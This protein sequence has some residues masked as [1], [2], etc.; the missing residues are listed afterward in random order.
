MSPN[1]RFAVL[2]LG[3][4]M[5]VAGVWLLALDDGSGWVLF[6]FSGLIVASLLLERRY[7]NRRA[8]PGTLRTSWERTGERFL[9]DETGRVLEVWI[10]PLT[11]ERRYE[12][13][14]PNGALISR[15]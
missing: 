15:P 2:A 6:L 3:A 12:P 9:D 10:D 14:S 8:S 13:E 11:G 7:N 4:L 5:A 1:A